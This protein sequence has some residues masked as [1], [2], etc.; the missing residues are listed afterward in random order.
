MNEKEKKTV[1]N[2]APIHHQVRSDGKSC[3]KV[4]GAKVQKGKSTSSGPR[5][6]EK[7]G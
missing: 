5:N 3:K 6:H 7:K 4:N 2:K 1:R